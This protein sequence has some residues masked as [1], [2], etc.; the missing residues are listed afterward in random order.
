[1]T[2]NGI[3]ASVNKANIEIPL[4]ISYARYKCERTQ[5]HKWCQR[6]NTHSHTCTQIQCDRTETT[7]VRVTA[8]RIS[9]RKCDIHT[10]A[11]RN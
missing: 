5:S 11:K 8:Y 2:L 4:K 6:E 7:L 9:A 1:M 10:F 3:D